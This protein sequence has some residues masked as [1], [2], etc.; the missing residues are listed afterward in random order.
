[1]RTYI[2]RHYTVSAK[3]VNG[4]TR[5]FEVESRSAQNAVDYIRRSITGEYEIT[6]VIRGQHKICTQWI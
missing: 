4:S 1:M 2:M 6:K 3:F 5:S